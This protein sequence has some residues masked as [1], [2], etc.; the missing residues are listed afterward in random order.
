MLFSNIPSP[1]EQSKQRFVAPLRNWPHPPNPQF[2][3][4]ACSACAFLF[5]LGLIL[6]QLIGLN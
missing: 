2:F 1:R 6:D 3:R 4:Y 5:F